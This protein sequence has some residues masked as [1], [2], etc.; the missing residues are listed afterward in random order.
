MTDTNFTPQ[1][2]NN[3]DVNNGDSK[4]FDFASLSFEETEPVSGFTAPDSKA[5][6]EKRKWWQSKPKDTRKERK[7]PSVKPMP[8]GGLKPALSQMYAGIGMAVM[9]FDP[10]CA[11]VIIENADKCAE[12]LDELAKTN[13]AVRRM[14]ISLVTTSAWGSVIMAHAPI[15]MAIMMHHVPALRDR[16]EKM[17]GEFAEMFANMAHDDKNGDSE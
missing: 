4:P 2:D 3:D 13:P 10:S 17:V 14:L 6:K 1:P 7:V 11:R 16:Q 15:V 8:R 12:S 9:P 5:G